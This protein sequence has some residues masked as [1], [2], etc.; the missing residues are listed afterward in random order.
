MIEIHFLASM[1]QTLV[2]LRYLDYMDGPDGID[3]ETIDA[4]IA[5]TETSMV[6]WRPVRADKQ[7]LERPDSQIWP[8]ISA[9]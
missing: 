7:T 5:E 1:R 2:M 4:L 8:A 6:L 3:E 9:N